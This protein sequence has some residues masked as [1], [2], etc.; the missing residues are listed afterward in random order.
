MKFVILILSI[1]LIQAISCYGFTSKTQSKLHHNDVVSLLKSKSKNENKQSKNITHF[2]K[3][4]TPQTV[5]PIKISESD[6]N[7]IESQEADLNDTMS[8]DWLKLRDNQLITQ[9]KDLFKKY[10]VTEA[11]GV[12][13]LF[14]L[15]YNNK[16]HEELATYEPTMINHI[17]QNKIEIVKPNSNSKRNV[18]R[19]Y[20]IHIDCFYL[21]SRVAI[22][23]F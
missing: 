5:Y 9:S 18:I 2:I 21:G 4:V 19:F 7:G 22:V 13:D 6:T 17:N 1:S 23:A 15:N 8:W 3:W 12:S 11:F 14:I 20:F 16:T 10:L